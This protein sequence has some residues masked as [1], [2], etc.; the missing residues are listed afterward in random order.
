[1]EDVGD[2]LKRTAELEVLGS[3]DDEMRKW[4]TYQLRQI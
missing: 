4:E 3:R 1:V 2:V